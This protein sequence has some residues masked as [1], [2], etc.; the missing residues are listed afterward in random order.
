MYLDNKR[1]SDD[2]KKLD[3]DGCFDFPKS[4]S[5]IKWL[6]SFTHKNDLIMDFF[7]GSGTV[8]QAVMEKNLED[9]GNR[10]FILVQFPEDLDANLA[11]ADG[12]SK[13]T[14]KRAIKL[15][16]SINVKHLLS[17]VSKERIRRAGKKIKEESPNIDVGFRALK[18]DESCMKEVYYLPEEMGQTRL[19]EL[20]DNIK[21]DRTPE[22]LLFQVML[23]IGI[24]LSSDIKTLDIYGKKVFN[25]NDSDLVCCFDDN[26]EENVIKEIAKMK[27]RYAV[28]RDSSM[29]SDS[30]NVNFDQI[31]KTYSPTT[32]KIK[33][34]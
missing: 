10:K 34:L 7:A 18:L 8:A 11:K 27:P 22:V 15:C 23:D 32:E 26:L 12:Q 9:C 2:I 14:I 4:V 21:E 6:L 3:L 33:V 25:V 24:M 13:E 17:E 20:E 30:L 16:D 5:L 29:S 28:F 31:F 1:G 19:A